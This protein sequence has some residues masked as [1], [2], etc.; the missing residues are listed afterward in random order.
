MDEEEEGKGVG[1]RTVSDRVSLST[2][3]SFLITTPDSTLWPDP[4]GDKT[5]EEAFGSALAFP[6]DWTLLVLLRL[7]DDLESDRPTP[8]LL[9]SATAAFSTIEV[10]P[11]PIRLRTLSKPNET[12]SLLLPLTFVSRTSDGVTG[13]RIRDST[14]VSDSPPAPIVSTSVTCASS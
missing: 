2:F 10:L 13:S 4:S 7:D 1:E 9:L 8:P 5:G 14:V 12:E 3:S 11:I 6:G